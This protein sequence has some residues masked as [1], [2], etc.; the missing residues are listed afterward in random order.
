MAPAPLRLVR[1]A[2]DLSTVAFVPT[3]PTNRQ[4]GRTREHLL[5]DEVEAL[6]EAAESNRYGHRDAL[7]VLL[8]Y[9]HG[10]RAKEVCDLKWEQV[11]FKASNLHVTRVKG[12]TDSTHPLTGREMRA[13]RRQ[14]RES[15]PSP[16]VFV[17][18]RGSPLTPTAFSKMIERAAAKAKLRIKAHAHMLRHACG[19]ALANAGVDTRSLQAYLGHANIANTV[20][21]AA[22][23]PQ[24]FN[25]FFKD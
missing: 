14:Q 18:E 10:L 12:G 13:L 5:K 3:R 19:F 1:P 25:G 22:L 16:W 21:Y 7:M 17:S 23:S 6:I 4:L 15:P 2:T 11:N 20:R 24:R 8:A 9:R